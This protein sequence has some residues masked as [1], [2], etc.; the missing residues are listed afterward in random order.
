MLAIPKHLM[1]QGQAA[2]RQPNVV[3]NMTQQNSSLQGNPAVILGASVA[4]RLSCAEEPDGD[5]AL[6]D[7][8]REG[9]R[10]SFVAEPDIWIYGLFHFMTYRHDIEPTQR[11]RS[12]LGWFYSFAFT[13]S[14]S[15]SSGAT[16]KRF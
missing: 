5:I 2:S 14:G 13:S 8:F 6:L 4:L 16:P 11:G 15:G 1:Q 7:G 9:L 10:V 3:Y 12:T